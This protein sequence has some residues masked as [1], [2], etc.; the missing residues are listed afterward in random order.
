[1]VEGNIGVNYLKETHHLARAAYLTTAACLAIFAIWGA[2]LVMSEEAEQYRMW[3]TTISCPDGSRTRVTGHSSEAQV[4]EA[5][6][7]FC[8]YNYQGY[9]ASS[10]IQVQINWFSATLP[11]LLTFF[12]LL[13]GS[14][15]L[16]LAIRY[17]H[18]ERMK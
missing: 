15:G 12:G 7:A 8:G 5:I 1:M 6:K 16:L 11:G 17:C 4:I 3:W 9:V 18:C 13:I 14:L 10:V 2:L